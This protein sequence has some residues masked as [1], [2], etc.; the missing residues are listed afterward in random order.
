SFAQD[1]TR[2]TGLATP[3]VLAAVWGLF[4]GGVVTPDTSSA[5]VDGTDAGGTRRRAHRGGGRRARSAAPGALRHRRPRA[6][7]GRLG[8]APSHAA[9]HGVRRRGGRGLLR[10]GTL[11]RAVRAGRRARRPRHARATR[12][13][14]RAGQHD[15]SRESLGPRLRPLAPRRLARCRGPP[16]S[17]LARLPSG[18]P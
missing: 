14:P 5:I 18:P 3:D 17:E 15:R 9:P 4:W 1:L 10:P 8:H 13:A 2:A 7:A 6:G 16:A 11:G 12:R